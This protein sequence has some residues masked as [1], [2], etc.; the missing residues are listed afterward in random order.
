MI[1]KSKLLS[2]YLNSVEGCKKLAVLLM[3]F[4]IVGGVQATETEHIYAVKIGDI[5]TQTPVLSELSDRFSIIGQSTMLSVL[6][7]RA[8]EKSR[9]SEGDDQYI[10]LMSLT[11]KLTKKE[12]KSLTLIKAA[13]KYGIPII[14]EVGIQSD[15]KSGRIKSLNGIATVIPNGDVHLLMP[16]K[17]DDR[18]ESD[19][20]QNRLLTYDYIKSAQA[21]TKSS[22]NND[23][24]SS[25]ETETDNTPS[26]ER[27]ALIAGKIENRLIKRF[28]QDI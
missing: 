2:F 3:L 28:E 20:P 19:R 11:S 12:M 18:G 15:D 6:K 14:T 7:A 1:R 17:V 24:V 13:K 16:G 22:D 5:D 10:L 4:T 9:D 23:D 27:I 8:A 26:S 25:D 21:Q